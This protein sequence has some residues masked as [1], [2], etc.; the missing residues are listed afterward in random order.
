MSVSMCLDVPYRLES[1]DDV[2]AA[3]Q[4]N[5]LE[6]G[7][8]FDPMLRV[9]RR[10]AFSI[11]S[12]LGKAQREVRKEFYRVHEET[13]RETRI[14]YEDLASL[15]PLHDVSSIEKRIPWARE[16]AQHQD[17]TQ[18]LRECSEEVRVFCLVEPPPQ[19]PMAVYES[20]LA[21]RKLFKQELLRYIKSGQMKSM[22]VDEMKRLIGAYC[23]FA[24]Q[25]E[26][27]LYALRP[28]NGPGLNDTRY[29]NAL[30]ELF[31]CRLPQAL[32]NLLAGDPQ[33]IRRKLFAKIGKLDMSVRQR[34]N[35][36]GYFPPDTRCADIIPALEKIDTVA[37]RMH[38]SGEAHQKLHDYLLS[39]KQTIART[40]MLYREF[41]DVD[42]ELERVQRLHMPGRVLKSHATYV[43]RILRTRTKLAELRFFPTK[44]YLD[45]HRGQISGD[46]VD[47]SLGEAQ[48]ATPN[49]FNVRVFDETQWIGN[50]YMLDFTD[51]Q[52]VLLIDRIQIPREMKVPYLQF[53]D[54]LA[55][56]LTEMF[57]DLTYECILA[58]LTISNHE[59]VQRAFNTYRKK[60][61]K[62]DIRLPSTYARYFE[63]LR[64]DAS[65]HV[66]CRKETN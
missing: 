10:T 29:G 26:D 2:L 32:E 53:F 66:L 36:Y 27:V 11:P 8:G 19:S 61:P 62:R 64:R 30:A 55:E 35:L 49:F 25:N 34:V 7:P 13:V 22:A 9:A 58:P 47:A 23:L 39:L 37:Q 12:A 4:A 14:R 54:T 38:L 17:F 40:A 15:S 31:F 42:G 46:C 5:L 43:E 16:I 45:L 3:K 28:V 63:S 65:F 18:V 20:A 50:L 1:L 56:A 60:L 24:P 6:I 52:G 21:I 48:L 51:E 44:D 41:F 59:T 57:R 33:A